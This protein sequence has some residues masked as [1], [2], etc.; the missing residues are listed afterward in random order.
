MN[1]LL[2]DLSR[3]VVDELISSPINSKCGIKLSLDKPLN[4]DICLNIF[5]P[6]VLRQYYGKEVANIDGKVKRCTYG[7]GT[8]SSSVGMDPNNFVTRSFNKDLSAMTDDI[9]DMLCNNRKMFNMLGVDLSQKFNHCTI[10]IYYAGKGLKKSTSLGYHT[11]CVYSPS[12]GEY[13]SNSN[14]QEA[15]TPAVIYSI[16]DKK[17]LNWKCRCIEKSTSGKINW[18]KKACIKMCF[19]LGTDSLTIIHP[20]DENPMSDKNKNELRQYFHGC[21]NVSGQKFSVGFIFRVVNQTSMYQGVDDTMFVD[22]TNGH[23]DVVNGVLGVDFLSF[24]RN[25]SNLYLSTLY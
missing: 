14:S 22:N 10:L 23:S 4:N 1:T 25:L 17:R 15:N 3:R 5:R 6:A 13:I 24:Q 7:S 2:Y 20:N 16:G 9:H 18:Q 8:G 21:V 19:E 11:D 12:T